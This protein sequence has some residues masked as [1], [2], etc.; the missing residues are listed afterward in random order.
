MRKHN[1]DIERYTYYR[2]IGWTWEEIA[3][4]LDIPESSIRSYIAYNFKEVI[5]YTYERKK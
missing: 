4:R 1:H 2:N 3:K 5:T